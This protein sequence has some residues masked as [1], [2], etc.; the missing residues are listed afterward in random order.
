MIYRLL[1]TNSLGGYFLADYT[2][3]EEA[4]AKKKQFEY[5]DNLTPTPQNS[6]HEV[7]IYKLPDELYNA[8]HNNELVWMGLQAS[9]QTEE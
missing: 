1:A 4:L 7:E 6:P 2:D 3:E 5:W 8:I 9:E